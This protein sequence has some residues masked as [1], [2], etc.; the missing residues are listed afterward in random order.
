M[1]RRDDLATI[2][3][4]LQSRRQA[5]SSAQR[6]MSTE[7]DA[8]KAADRDPE[9]EESAQVAQAEY[10]LTTIHDSHQREIEQIDAALDRIDDGS[11]GVCVDCE[12]EIPPDRLLAVP[13]SLRCADCATARENR[14]ARHSPATM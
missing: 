11:Y 1:T 10:T 12:L 6:G 13:Y 3:K 9:Y 7:L 4:M 8:L 2:K 14:L 5:L